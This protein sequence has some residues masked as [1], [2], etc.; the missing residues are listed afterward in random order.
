[1]AVVLLVACA[2]QFAEDAGDP[3]ATERAEL[4]G[5]QN[6][7]TQAIVEGAVVGGVVGALT[8]YLTGKST[9][10]AVAG[11]GIGAV[12][13]GI[14][15]YYLAKQ[16]VASD[17]T[18]LSN[19]ILKDVQAENAEIDRATVAFAKLR[20]CR[21]TAAQQVKAEF[22]A[23][24]ISRAQAISRLDELQARFNQDLAIADEVG[25][26]MADKSREFVYASDQLVAENPEAKSYLASYPITSEAPV[27]PTTETRVAPSPK[28]APKPKVVTRAPSPPPKAPPPKAAPVVAVAQETNTNQLKQK[29]YSNEVAVAKSESSKAF[30]L[31]GQVGLILPVCP[32]CTHG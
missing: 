4:R 23:G 5:A 17:A 7:Y 28:P 18:A 3:C 6:Y 22:A 16:K 19:S 13:G 24:R 20:N 30:S 1:M 26:K 10:A 2:T 32:A 9:K 15:G 31:E 21:F 14:G 27:T 8:G 29:K 11:A 12:A 25:T